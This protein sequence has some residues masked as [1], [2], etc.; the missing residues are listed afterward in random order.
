ML[1]NT[2]LGLTQILP[3]LDE[4]TGA[5]PR[6]ISASIADPYLLLIRDDSSVLIAQIDSNNELEEVEKTDNTLQSTKWHAGCL[7]TDTKGIF[8]PSVGDKGADTSKI[9]MFLLSSTGA[10]HVSYKLILHFH[11]ANFSRSTRFPISQSQSTSL[12]ACVMFLLTS[13][14]TILSAEAWLERISAS[15]WWQILETLYPNHHISS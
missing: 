12:K 4:E 3:M 6:V 15:C 5:E 2:D 14:Q 11:L 8:Q 7:Y 9:M 10:L 13:L 1:T